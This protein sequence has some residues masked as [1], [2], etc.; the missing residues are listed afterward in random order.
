[1]PRKKRRRAIRI[2]RLAAIAASIGFGCVL[3]TAHAAFVLYLDD[4][5]TTGIDVIVSDE[6]GTGFATSVCNTNAA[7]AYGGA[8]TVTYL[9]SVG[10]FSVNVTTGVSKPELTGGVL[11]LNSINVSGG[12]G[13]TLVIGLTD[14]GFLG[15]TAGY[16]A[17]Y[18]G[19]TSTNGVASPGGTGSVTLEFYHDPI[20]VE[21][22]PASIFNSGPLGG[23]TF[24]GSATLGFTAGTP[25]SLSIIATIDHGAG[26]HNT[27]FDAELRPQPVPV[28]AAVW[29]FGTGLV[30][31]VAV[32]RR[33]C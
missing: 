2:S 1:M 20:N 33:R 22:G 30:G 10:N 12:A 25:Y 14:T 31:L 17:N 5:G 11:D 21:F 7:D 3:N 27:S 9:G 8:G 32:A 13:S 19:T 29:L 26:S 23:P 4:I 6:Q 18:G 15:T 24:D 16:T 28:P